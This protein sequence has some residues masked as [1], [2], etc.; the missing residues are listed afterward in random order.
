MWM[1]FELVGREPPRALDLR[2]HLVAAP[3]D[4]EAVDEVA[5]QHRRQIGADLLHAQAH[6]RHL[7]AIDDDL[8]LRLVDA[9]VGDGREG[10][11]AALHRLLHELLSRTGGAP[12]GSPSTTSTNS[13]GKV[14]AL[15]SAAGRNTGARTPVIAASS[16][17]SSSW[18]GKMLRLRSS[19]GLTSMPPKPPRGER[20]LEA[21]IELGRRLE[22]PVDRPRCTA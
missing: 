6:R 17:C 18:I 8:G 5:A 19:H 22:V 11:L 4:V 3:V 14:P 7:V 2:D 16:C 13:T 20:D 15:G 10:E 9:H 21:V 12:R 1:S